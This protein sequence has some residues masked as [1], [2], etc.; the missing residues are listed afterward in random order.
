[1]KSVTFVFFFAFSPHDKITMTCPGSTFCECLVLSIMEGASGHNVLTRSAFHTLCVSTYMILIPT[2]LVLCR[3]HRH[4]VQP[5][6]L[7]DQNTRPP[8]PIFP[9]VFLELVY[10]LDCT[11]YQSDCTNWL[12]RTLRMSPGTSMISR[13]DILLEP[14]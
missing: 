1:V 11:T 3:C 4:L 6:N 2:R 10:I 5:N 14:R 12:D 9:R 13:V 7:L 8:I